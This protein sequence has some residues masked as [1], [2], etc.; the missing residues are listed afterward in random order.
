MHDIG[1]I[2]CVLNLNKPGKLTQDE[3][4][5]FKKHPGYG[6]DI[7]EPIKFLHPLIPGV[8]LHHER[9]DGRGYPLGLKGNDDPAHRAHHR[10]RRHLRRDD[11]RSRLPPRAPARGRRH[12][13]RALLGDAVRSRGLATRSAKASTSTARASS[14]RGTRSPNDR[15][16]PRARSLARACS[17]SRSAAALVALA[18]ALSSP[19]AG[20]R[21]C[22]SESRP[23]RRRHRTTSGRRPRRRRPMRS[24]VKSALESADGA[25]VRVR[26][27]LVAVDAP[28]PA[29]NVG[30]P[31]RSTKTCSVERRR[32]TAR[33][34][35]TG[36][37]PCPD[38]AATISDEVPTAS[39]RA[40]EPDAPRGRGG[41]RA[42]ASSRRPPLP[43]HRRVP[44]HGRESGPEL[45]VTDVRAIDAR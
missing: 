31:A 21:T 3:Y 30:A 14:R 27:Y 19:D 39:A 17:R 34:T 1:K 36:C 24:T 2:G 11:E 22:R 45:E 37:L 29:C 28:C 26:A 18:R 40:E 15:A 33:S 43:A 42:A 7:L 16:R 32:A 13:D 12:R 10:R 44:R 41:G 38:P 23:R 4:E 9:W 8:H 5:I 6:R 35:P 25:Q 20:A